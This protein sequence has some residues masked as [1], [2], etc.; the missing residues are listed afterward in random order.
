[1]ACGL[2]GESLWS[3]SES[4]GEF[5]NYLTYEGMPGPYWIATEDPSSCKTLTIDTEVCSRPCDEPL[6]VLCTQSAPLSN[7]TYADNSTTW[8][9]TVTSASQSWTGFRDKFSFRFEGI[10][11]A[12]QPDRFIY[13][14]VFNEPGEYD[15]LTFGSE[16]VQADDVGSE[17]CLFLNIWTPYT[18]S[19]NTAPTQKL[20]PVML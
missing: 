4:N 3:L 13:S 6:P 8:R 15:A 16:C 20:K 9:T 17:D 1:M 12:P 7:L 10:R 19:S 2:L 18:P 5:L 11:Y 14:T